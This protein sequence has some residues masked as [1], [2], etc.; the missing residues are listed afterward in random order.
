VELAVN[1]SGPAADLVA[2]GRITIDR[3]KCPAWPDLIAAMPKLLPIYVHFPL[4]VG[5]GIGDAIDSETREAADWGKIEALREETATPLINLH[6]ESFAADH[7]DIPVDSIA[8]E[9]IERVSDA[10]I[11]DV[12]TVVA[13]FGAERVIVENLYD[14]SGK[15]LYASFL[16]EVIGRVVATTG[17]GFLLDLSHARIAAR[18][19]GID[20]RDYLAELPVQ[21][22]RELHVTGIAPI[23]ERFLATVRQAGLPID[24]WERLAGRW[25]DHMALADGDWSFV[26]WA[27][28]QIRAGAWGRPWVVSLEYGGIGRI[29]GAFSDATVLAEAVPRLYDLVQTL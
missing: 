10:F 5:R 6:L 2:T 4:M 18:I 14:L 24:R 3:F 9:H 29:L 25:I 7:P 8:R 27:F 15:H 22:I 21:N 17:C 23:D 12:V 26:N 13:R 19:L 28:E 11:T 16:P 20:P 1:Y